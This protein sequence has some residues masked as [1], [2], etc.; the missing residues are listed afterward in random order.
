MFINYVNFSSSNL[1]HRK[2]S[3]VQSCNLRTLQSLYSVHKCISISR[4]L[5][6]SVPA[7]SNTM[8][9]I[10]FLPFVSGYNGKTSG[11]VKLFP[12][13]L[14]HTMVNCLTDVDA[15]RTNVGNIRGSLGSN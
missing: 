11:K 1:T 13:A 8:I 14:F 2:Y 4:L 3:E 12:T 9:L 10:V 5:S 6:M 7:K 15:K